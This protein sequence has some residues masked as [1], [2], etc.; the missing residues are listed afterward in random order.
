MA[1]RSIAFVLSV[2][3]RV[4][5]LLASRSSSCSLDLREIGVVY[6]VRRTE[7]DWKPGG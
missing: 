1:R 3:R 6:A 5:L 2:G 4:S 7:F